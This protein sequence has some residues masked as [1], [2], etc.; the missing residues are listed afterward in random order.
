MIASTIVFTD[1]EIF[2]ARN[3]AS[4]QVKIEQAEDLANN[5][6]DLFNRNLS[7]FAE[8]YKLS[9]R[10]TEIAEQ[11][12]RGRTI[13]YIAKQLYIAPGTVKTHMHNIYSKLDIHNKM[14]LL[15]A[16]EQISQ[17]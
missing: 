11:L 5:A 8:R 9:A 15:D 17:E 7:Q 6:E 1:K 12:L 4:D 16:F 14:E 10:E 2:E 13:N 3:V